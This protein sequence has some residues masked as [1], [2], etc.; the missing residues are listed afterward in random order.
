M[1]SE[2]VAIHECST[3]HKGGGE[4]ERS[5]GDVM[6][7]WCPRP[8]LAEKKFV[9]SQTVRSV[10]VD[11]NYETKR[12]VYIGLF[13]FSTC[14]GNSTVNVGVFRPP[15][16]LRLGGLLDFS[17]FIEIKR[18]VLVSSESLASSVGWARM[19]RVESKTR[20]RGLR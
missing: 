1:N 6:T 14:H 3:G 18:Q 5:G 13:S 9:V 15:I 19:S 8:C 12:F 17:Y 16:K 10:G 2:A 4:G 7:W 11:T 20:G